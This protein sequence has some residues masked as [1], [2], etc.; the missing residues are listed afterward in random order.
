MTN[1]ILEIGK[2]AFQQMIEYV[3]KGEDNEMVL[4]ET[5]HVQFPL[6]IIKKRAFSSYN[7][8]TKIN[9]PSTVEVIEDEACYGRE[10]LT[11]LNIPSSVKQIGREAFAECESLISINIP[12]SVKVIH[13]QTFF[14]VCIF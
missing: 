2:W 4:D 12:S 11:G 7:F 13:S 10:S 5:T 3:Y 6:S 1:I 9:I 8:L 14:C